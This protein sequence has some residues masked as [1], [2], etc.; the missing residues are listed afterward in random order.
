M[1]IATKRLLLRPFSLDDID[2]V[3]AY[4]SN[5]NV[6]KYMEWGPN[7]YED[8]KTFV[9]SV[10]RNHHNPARLN[11]DFIVSLKDG[12]VIGACSLNFQELDK[13]PSLG[14]VY[15]EDFWGQ[16]YGTEVGYALLS[17][18]FKTLKLR[19]VYATCDKENIG[20]KRIMEKIGMRFVEEKEC[21]SKKMGS[22]IE[23]RYEL[24]ALEYNLNN[25]KTFI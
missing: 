5:L 22:R 7:T 1:K 3:H 11:H 23:L 25:H 19:K 6:T 13:A 12:K 16:G 2:D 18:A 15:H 20:S 9:K 10:V 4:S 14:W 21:S 24:T 8:T 17:Y